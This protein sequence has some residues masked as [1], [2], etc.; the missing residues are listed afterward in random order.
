[1][2]IK[3]TLIGITIAGLVLAAGFG[4]VIYRQANAQEPEPQVEIPLGMEGKPLG[5]LGIGFEAR[6]GYANEDL[7]EALGI[8]V[9]ELNEAF[10]QAG[11]A[12][13]DQ[14][15]QAGLITEAQ[16]EQL[17]ERGSAFPFGR[18]SSRWFDQSEIN[19]NALLAEA[20]GI[21]EQ[22]LEQAYQQAFITRIDRQLAEGRLTQEQADLLKG[23][24]ALSRSESFQSS[25]QSA[26]EAALQQAVSQGLITQTQADLILENQQQRG[27]WGPGLFHPGGR[28]HRGRGPGGFRGLP[29]SS[30]DSIPSGE[31]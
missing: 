9:E 30:A 11:E 25:M 16:A 14:A 2:I 27:D 31:G 17:R 7:A 13:L 15:V 12:A 29:G 20:L 24:Y 1:M 5:N 4:L 22:E 28:G 6:G 18:M 21:S 19:F 8:T 26:F 23:Q 10:Q 3:R